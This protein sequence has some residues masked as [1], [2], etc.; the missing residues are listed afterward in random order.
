MNVQTFVVVVLFFLFETVYTMKCLQ[1]EMCRVPK[2]PGKF[3]IL[4]VTFFQSQTISEYVF[5]VKMP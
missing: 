2:H 4:E 5:N 3:G 1:N